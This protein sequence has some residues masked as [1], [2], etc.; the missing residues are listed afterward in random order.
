MSVC[1]HSNKINS[2]DDG[3]DDD[4]EVEDDED[5]LTWETKRLE[6]IFE[7]YSLNEL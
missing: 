1:Q 4:G 3:E 7:S 6:I 5:W 2:D